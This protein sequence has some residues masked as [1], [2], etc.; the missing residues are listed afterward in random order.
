[1]SDLPGILC[2]HT[3]GTSY[4]RT[5]NCP[6]NCSMIDCAV[7]YVHVAREYK[8][9]DHTV[10]FRLSFIVPHLSAHP[11]CE[12]TT[13]MHA[14]SLQLG[15]MHIVKHWSLGCQARSRHGCRDLVITRTGW[16]PTGGCAQLMSNSTGLVTFVIRSESIRSLDTG[17]NMCYTVGVS[18]HL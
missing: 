18:Y 13:W 5:V 11:M 14:R 12:P 16:N 1:M 3:Q 15:G 2:W 7:L 10:P 8:Q 17:E 6:S 9:Q 4:N